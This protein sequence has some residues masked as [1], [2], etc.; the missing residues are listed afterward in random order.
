MTDQTAPH[1]TPE[2]VNELLAALTYE[3]VRMPNSSVTV[4]EARLPGGFVVAIGYSGY[5]SPANFDPE[6]G[7]KRAI[8]HARQKAEEALWRYEGYALARELVQQAGN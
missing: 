2:R 6:A 8:G 7:A 5:V 1:V 3:T 4:A